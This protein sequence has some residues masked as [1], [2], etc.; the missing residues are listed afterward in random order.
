MATDLLDT[1]LATFAE[2][3]RDAGLQIKAPGK[4]WV[5]MPD[6]APGSHVSL[7]VRRKAI[8]V[9]LNN[10]RD[11]DRSRFNALYPYRKAI[12]DVIGESLS[13]EKKE[14]RSKTAVRATLELGHEH[15]EDWDKQH[16]WAIQT[17]QLFEQA[18]GS[19]VRE[20]R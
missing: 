1:Y 5:A 17:M 15:V 20:A 13:W 6:L 18:F 7:S 3:A 10:E 14:G 4:N 12:Q 9:N 19:R 2:R 11:S 8:Q 16:A